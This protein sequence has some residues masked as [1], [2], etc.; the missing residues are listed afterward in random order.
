MICGCLGSVFNKM[1]VD[2]CHN[3]YG[4]IERNYQKSAEVIVVRRSK[5]RRTE[6]GSK[7]MKRLFVS[8]GRVTEADRENYRAH[9]RDN[10]RK[11]GGIE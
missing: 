9:G 3:L 4:D 6:H 11:A 10:A 7:T 1:N 8:T 5:G 2:L